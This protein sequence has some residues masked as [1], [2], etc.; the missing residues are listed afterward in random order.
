MAKSTQQECFVIM[1]I[2][3]HDGYEK[4]HFRRVYE[5]I[6]IPAC[7]KSEYKAVRADEVEQTDIIHLSILKK[8]IEAPMAICDLST[9]NPNVL[10]ELG[11]RQAF[12]KP[13][14]LIQEKGTERIFDVSI[15]RA[16]DYCKELRYNEVLK[17]QDAIAK[18]LKG[19]EK[20]FVT[21]EGFNSVIKL[22]GLARG[23][24]IQT[25]DDPN[26]QLKMQ[27]FQLSSQVQDVS[28]ELRNIKHS[29]KG[30]LNLESNENLVKSSNDENV[31]RAR[32]SI[33]FYHNR[34]D[35]AFKRKDRNE[36]QRIFDLC[37]RRGY[38]DTDRG[39]K[40]LNEMEEAFKTL[41]LP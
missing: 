5:D 22:L 32:P 23:A 20:G 2:S 29:N 16:Y 35:E 21:G 8:I 10:F 9:R 30:L 39:M 18:M 34:F 19:T 31:F 1:P 14:V 40:I 12:D 6:I 11:L 36:M 33:I 7:D 26:E 13:V 3:D 17:D 41:D 28:N 25:I 15:L 37:S 27:L 24:Q 38:F 4:G